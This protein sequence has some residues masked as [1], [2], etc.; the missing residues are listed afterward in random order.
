MAEKTIDITRCTRCNRCVEIC[1]I[2]IWEIDAATG[3]PAVS[4]PRDKRCTACGH[5]EAICP[6]NAIAVC[7]GNLRD[8]Y[9][10]SADAALSP[11]QV[12]AYFTARR[13]TR[14]FISEPVERQTL[15]KILDIARHAPS[16]VNRQPVTW[17]VVN[18][19]VAV[20]NLAALAAEWMRGQ[21]LSMTPISLALRFDVLLD[22]WEKGKD[23]L[24]R[25]APACVFASAHR[26]DRMAG[27]DGTIALAHV[28]LAAP[29]FGL[30]A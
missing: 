12:A 29:A 18:S 11:E 16:G 22:S 7:G 25:N 28:E 5:C 2:E 26:E 30:G 15:E 17:S 14:R 9:V 6:V 13:S 21:L 23:P 4:L 20:K 8:A 19:P 27:T 3:F 1:P 24:C 10:P